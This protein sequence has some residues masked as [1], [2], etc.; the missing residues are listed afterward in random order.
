VTRPDAFASDDVPDAS[1]GRTVSMAVIGAGPG[2]TGVLERL[3][4][5]VPELL[6][7]RPIVVHMIDPFPPGAGR[8]WRHEQSALVRMNSMAQ[9]V[10]MFTDDTVICDGPIIP[11]P[12][13]IEWAAIVDGADLPD[14]DVAAEVRALTGTTFPTRRLQAAY[15]NWTF[16]RIVTDAPSNVRV[17][18]H[19]GRAVDLSDRPDGRQDVTLDDGAVFVADVV[20]LALGHVDA[21]AD[22]AAS[23]LVEFADR[24]G[25]FYLPPSY[26][27]DEDLS[28]VPAGAD[29]IVSGMGLAFI[30]LVVLLTEGRGGRY[31]HREE[32]GLDY[33]P[34]GREPIIHAGSRRGV[35]YRSKLLQRLQGAPPTLPRFLTADAVDELLDR[36]GLL[37]FRRDV[38]PLIAKEI[39][40]GYYQELFT[41]HPD[42][43]ATPWDEFADAYA[44][45]G[46]DA[47]E[48]A[49]LAATA[50]PDPAD[51][52][53]LDLLDRPLRGR[54]FDSADAVGSFVADGIID[55]HRRAHDQAHSADLGAFTALLSC[56]GQLP[57]IAASPKLTRRSRVE[58]AD[59]WFFGFF[60]YLASGPPGHRLEELLALWRAGIL[61]F[62]GADLRVDADDAT[63][64]FI[65]TSSSSSTI[66]AAAALIDARL[67]TPHLER[68]HDPLLRRLYQRGE[69]AQGQLVDEH[70]GTVH[71]TGLIDVDAEA[72]RMVTRTGEAH[73]RRHAVGAPTNRRVAGTFSRPRTNAVAFRQTD[74]L[75]RSVL[76][77]LRN[78]QTAEAERASA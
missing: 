77:A 64:R 40:W 59:G 49:A 28:G 76:D 42:R 20:V 73:P 31:A 71:G 66:V 21:D 54:R 1:S 60:S 2:G 7:D 3:T 38:Y 68:T 22:P 74:A 51:R 12:S 72:L 48:L 78:A 37:D 58:D 35:P 26:T 9:D 53:D 13:L 14:P 29:V 57:R 17:V 15:L 63:G 46:V 19:S 11:G 4:A 25:L 43:V 6:A 24:H 30:D 50:V 27:A 61:R 33:L 36:D 69:A 62:L 23:Q 56:F 47:A 18:V 70:E 44:A 41:G 67:P 39:G 5:N 45:A 32:G 34:S 8:V 10:T 55:N 65:A 16:R 75:A 52:L